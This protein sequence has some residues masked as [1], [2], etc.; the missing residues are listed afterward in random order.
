MSLVYEKNGRRLGT[1]ENGIAWWLSMEI[2]D[3]EAGE[4]VGW[5]GEVRCICKKNFLA[6]SGRRWNVEGQK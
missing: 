3:Q 2:F 6:D 4:K 5:W 1:K